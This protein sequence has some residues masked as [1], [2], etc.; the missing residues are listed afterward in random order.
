MRFTLSIWAM[1][2]RIR[3]LSKNEFARNVF[4]LMSGTTVAQGIAILIY[5]VLAKIYTTSEHGVFA[6][7]L[8]II[9]VTGIISTG[10][11]EAAIMM[12]P[13]EKKAFNLVALGSLLCV[14]FSLILLVL[15]A[16][17]HQGFAVLLGDPLIEKW[18]WFVPLSTLMIGLFQIL[19]YWSN[20]NK[21]FGSMAVANVGQSLTNSAVKVSASK[22]FANGGGLIVG[23]IIGQFIGIVLFL[24]DFL[25]K[26]IALVG[27]VSVSGMKE[28]AK[29]F[30]FFPRFN[31][32]HNLIN[33]LSSNLPVFVIASNFGTAEAGLYSFG[34]LMVFRPV[35]LVTSSF[36]QVFSQRVISQY[37]QGKKIYTDVRRMAM[38][39]FKFG[40][41]PFLIAGIGGPILFRIFF[42]T[43]WIEAGRYMQILL[44]W[45][46]V[47]LVSA[48]LSF[49]PD[50][51]KRQQAAMWLDVLKI[52]VRIPALAI[53][54]YYNNI[55]LAVVLFSGVSFLSVGYSLFWYLRIAKDSDKT[56]S[57]QRTPAVDVNILN[58]DVQ[59]I[60][61]F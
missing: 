23:A 39:L 22:V 4:T 1:L 38:Q 31:M 16:F 41:I 32:I 58:E 2:K 59:N 18:L 46:F 13:E 40:I 9:A 6:L 33:N 34:F 53:G 51:L 35:S 11:F 56:N 12:P 54:V 45:I 37:N 27:K 14:A 50:M 3:D 17:F 42:G 26:D 57:N 24:W 47:V 7:F 28:M 60:Q 10:K 44:P 21:R 49:L 25:K 52:A 43:T 55:Y 61:D 30:S 36:S 19:S 29:E 15:V 8:S 20:R 48:P 5:L